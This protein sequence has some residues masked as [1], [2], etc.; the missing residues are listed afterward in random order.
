MGTGLRSTAASSLRAAEIRRRIVTSVTDWDNMSRTLDRCRDLIVREVDAVFAD[1][2]EALEE[3]LKPYIL[4]QEY[5]IKH[6]WSPSTE[7]CSLLV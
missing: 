1:R 6:F 3:S 4:G 2:R 7:L 5:H